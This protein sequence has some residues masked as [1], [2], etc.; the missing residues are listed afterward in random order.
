MVL[1]HVVLVRTWFYT[2]PLSKGLCLIAKETKQRSDNLIIYIQIPLNIKSFHWIVPQRLLNQPQSTSL[3]FKSIICVTQSLANTI[4]QYTY[5]QYFI[6]NTALYLF[7]SSVYLCFFLSN[8]WI[9]KSS[10][11]PPSRVFGW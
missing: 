8:G 3:I 2:K 5:I 6:K 9:N 10:P 11:P 1:N 4:L 7:T